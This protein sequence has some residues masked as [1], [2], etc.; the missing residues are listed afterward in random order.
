MKYIAEKQNG[1]V[2]IELTPIEWGTIEN[3]IEAYG[4]N[5]PP[6]PHLQPGGRPDGDQ[7]ITGWIEAMMIWTKTVERVWELRELIN[8]LGEKVAL[9]K[10]E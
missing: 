3:M 4:E 2:L 6:H 10:R 9:G 7:P 5:D 8:I 1:N